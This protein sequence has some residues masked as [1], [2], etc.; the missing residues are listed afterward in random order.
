MHARIWLS[1][2]LILGLVL[3]GCSRAPEPVPLP[4]PSDTRSD[5]ATDELAQFYDQQLEWRDCGDAECTR[6]TVPLDYSNIDGR[7]T[8]LAMIRVPATGQAIGSLFVNPGGP[9]GSA[10]DYARAADYIVTPEIREVFDIVGVDPRGVAKSDPIR[11]LT[12]SEVDELFAADG[13]P[14]NPTEEAQ[15]IEDSGRLAQACDERAG[16]VWQYMDTVANARDMDIV[17]SLVGDPVLNYLGKSYG[18]AIGATYAE[19]FPTRVGRMV[20]DGALPVTLSQEEVT[21]GQAV[22]FEQSFG[23]FAAD[24]A[25]L[26]DCPFSGSA[27][28]VETELRDFLAGLDASPLSTDSGRELTQSLGTYAILSF[29]YFPSGD[30]PRLRDAL[31]EAVENNDGS[32]LLALVDERTSRAPDG[33]YLDNSTDAFYAVTCADMPYNGTS[34]DVARLASEWQSQAP[35]FGESLAWGLLACANWP[36]ESERLTAVT[37]K[38]SAPI[39]VVST[40][41]DPATPHQWGVD[42]ARSLENGHLI[43]W[44]ATNH[45]AY[46]EGSSCVDAAVDAYLLTGG[47]PPVDLTCE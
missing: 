10:F 1:A 3:A 37:A 5:A 44:N 14:D 2:A 45:T 26:G 31:S 47:V 22:S 41:Q 33:R 42:L 8:E 38:G 15:L 11:C 16:E 4:E 17:R 19:L 13:T 6:V 43:T 36:V 30:Y 9:G 12:D 40:T 20:L 24:C 32:P 35:T 25:A 18:T 46:N 7:T 34:E 29:L 27:S 39:L 23:D 21:F 28:E